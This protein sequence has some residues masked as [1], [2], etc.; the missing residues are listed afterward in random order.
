MGEENHEKLAFTEGAEGNIRSVVKDAVAEAESGYVAAGVGGARQGRRMRGGI[1]KQGKKA[2]ENFEGPSGPS[3]TAPAPN[4]GP[5]YGVPVDMSETADSALRTVLDNLEETKAELIDKLNVLLMVRFMKGQVPQPDAVL[6]DVSFGEDGVALLTLSDGVVLKVSH[7]ENAAT[8]GM[9]WAAEY[10]SSPAEVQKGGAGGQKK[11]LKTLS[12]SAALSYVGLWIDTR[13][14]T[15]F[16]AAMRRARRKVAGYAQTIGAGG[17]AIAEDVIEVFAGVVAVGMFSREVC[18]VSGAMKFKWG[19]VETVVD[20]DTINSELVRKYT[21]SLFDVDRV[22]LFAESLRTGNEVEKRASFALMKLLHESVLSAIKHILVSD[23]A[24][25]L[26]ALLSR[27]IKTTQGASLTFHFVQLYPGHVDTIS[28]MFIG[29]TLRGHEVQETFYY[30]NGLEWIIPRDSDFANQYQNY[31]AMLRAGDTPDLETFSR[32]FASMQKH[33]QGILK[34]AKEHDFDQYPIQRILFDA[35]Y[36]KDGTKPITGKDL[37][38]LTSYLTGNNATRVFLGYYEGRNYLRITFYE[39][40]VNKDPDFLL[41]FLDNIN[42]DA[43]AKKSYKDAHTSEDD[44]SIRIDIVMKAIIGKPRDSPETLDQYASKLREVYFKHRSILEV[45]PMDTEA[46]NQ[47]ALAFLK[48]NMPWGCNVVGQDRYDDIKRV[49]FAW[50]TLV[51]HSAGVNIHEELKTV[52]DSMTESTSTKG[53]FSH[54]FK[55]TK[56]HVFYNTGSD[57]IQELTYADLMVP[58]QEFILQQMIDAAGEEAA[59]GTYVATDDYCL[60]SLDTFETEM[61]SYA[62]AVSVTD[63]F[64]FTEAAV[65]IS[66]ESE[67]NVGRDIGMQNKLREKI[68]YGELGSGCVHG[69]DCLGLYSFDNDSIPHNVVKRTGD[70]FR[71]PLM[72]FSVQ[73]R[74]KGKGEIKHHQCMCAAHILATRLGRTSSKLVESG[75]YDRYTL[76]VP[77]SKPSPFFLTIFG[78]PWY[79]RTK[80]REI[81]YAEEVRENQTS[82]GYYAPEAGVDGIALHVGGSLDG[83]ALSL[84]SIAFLGAVTVAA[85]LCKRS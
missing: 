19:G 82:T 73:L 49:M 24:L 75:L 3:G 54:A 7:E 29:T 46:I 62:E 36:N 18:W 11:T 77:A 30:K 66:T 79:T 33:L 65:Q 39:A 68:C 76:N 47:A 42:A 5:D 8:G 28:V 41:K 45:Q 25:M 43:P 17:V 81:M 34:T 2:G 21:R 31:V 15:I 26:N 52:I 69:R 64:N 40:L 27:S 84:L 16:E 48:K 63:E 35:Y 58:K 14:F 38:D 50:L 23:D 78:N 59:S 55:H 51:K 74:E 1:S 57:D 60:K 44:N 61:A 70:M 37:A 9:S 53:W 12:F 13:R 10:V 56:F 80:W 72:Y 83:S 20:D 85:S 67:T 4:G 6:S 22:G 71:N 32:N